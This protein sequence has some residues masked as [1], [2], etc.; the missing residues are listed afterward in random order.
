MKK[1]LFLLFLAPLLAFTEWVPLEMDQ[2][3]SI[4]F[5][6]KPLQGKMVNID[7]MWYLNVDDQTKFV[8]SKIDNKRMGIDSVQLANDI[9]KPEALEVI[10]SQIM[11]S[12]PGA[13]VIKESKST[14]NGFT[15]FNYEFSLKDNTVI[16]YYRNI[17]VGSCVYNVIC[18]RPAGSSAEETEEFLKSI[19]IK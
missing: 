14:L 8:V 3:F 9:N 15:S 7:D 13:K 12:L 5:P 6:G 16:M 10:K 18:T 19:T 17:F 2:R 1:L 11:T 4:R